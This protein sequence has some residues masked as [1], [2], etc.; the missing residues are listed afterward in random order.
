MGFYL[1]R[2]PT[3]RPASV[4]QTTRSPLSQQTTPWGRAIWKAR[5]TLPL[6][7][8]QSRREIAF[9]LVAERSSELRYGR[10]QKQ[11]LAFILR[12]YQMSSDSRQEMMNVKIKPDI[13]TQL[14]SI[15]NHDIWN[16]L[17]VS[18]GTWPAME[19][20]ES[21]LA[22]IRSGSIGGQSTDIPLNVRACQGSDGKEGA[23]DGEI[24]DE[25]VEAWEFE[26]EDD[27]DEDDDYDDSG[28]YDDDTDGYTARTRRDLFSA[29]SL[30]FPQTVRDSNSLD[31]TAQN[32]QQ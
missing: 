16:H 18:K 19:R 6:S 2:V 22:G 13:S 14:D 8:L 11:F 12:T 31:S 1:P 21:P 7:R 29:A 10:T 23:E 26:N 20:Q 28:Y 3:R 30:D 9:N 5:R 17:D 25:N 32:C 27:D 15:W 24:D 4:D